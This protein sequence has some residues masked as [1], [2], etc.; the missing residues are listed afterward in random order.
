MYADEYDKQGLLLLYIFIFQDNELYFLLLK[1]LFFVCVTH[2]KFGYNSNCLKNGTEPDLCKENNKQRKSNQIQTC[3]KGH[4]CT[5]GVNTKQTTKVKTTQG[6]NTEEDRQRLWWILLSWKCI[7][8]LLTYVVL[9][10]REFHHMFIEK[11]VA[12]TT[13]FQMYVMSLQT[14]SVSC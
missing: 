4:T 5:E 1:L 2:E 11:I 14:Y 8:I 12:D 10:D 6:H 9:C 3:R 7:N 13:S